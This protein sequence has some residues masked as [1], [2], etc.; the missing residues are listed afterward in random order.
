MFCTLVGFLKLTKQRCCINHYNLQ[1]YENR[2]YYNINTHNTSVSSET[3]ITAAYHNIVF[4][5]VKVRA[6]SNYI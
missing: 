5:V 4:N 1:P 6:L 2:K 3:I